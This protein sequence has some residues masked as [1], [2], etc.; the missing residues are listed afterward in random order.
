M[1]YVS[2]QGHLLPVTR[3]RNLGASVL[4]LSALESP[5]ETQAVVSDGTVPESREEE[6]E[7]VSF[8]SGCW[9]PTASRSL[10]A[11][12]M[13]LLACLTPLAPQQKDPVPS[14]RGQIR[15]EALARH[16]LKQI[17]GARNESGTGKDIP[18]QDDKASGSLSPGE[19]VLWATTPLH[20]AEGGGGLKNASAKCM[21][22]TKAELTL[23]SVT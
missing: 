14:L 11:A 3:S 7:E 5:G 15:A 22:Q 9:S 17:K 8:S 21:L 13:E 12:D 6:T 23:E 1:K 10:L 19:G 16:H 4:S 20:V 2:S 18:T